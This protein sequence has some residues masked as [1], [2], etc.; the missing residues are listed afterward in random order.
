MK[1]KKKQYI[2]NGVILTFLYSQVLLKGFKIECKGI[3]I[4]K[5]LQFSK[6]LREESNRKLICFH[7]APHVNLYIAYTS[8][9]D[10]NVCLL[11]ICNFM[12]FLQTPKRSIFMAILRQA[13][14]S[15]IAHLDMAMI[16][17]FK[18][19]KNADQHEKWLLNICLEVMAK[20]V[21][22]LLVVWPH[23]ALLLMNFIL[24]FTI[25]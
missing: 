7:S 18:Y 19:S 24:V 4:Y 25:M 14:M 9:N 16:M 10:L 1:K 15:V 23:F 3:Y 11:S 17:V 2:F 20:F 5:H 22:I 6:I 13:K 21:P 12:Y 8:K